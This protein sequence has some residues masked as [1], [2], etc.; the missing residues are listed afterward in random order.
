MRPLLLLAATALALG[1]IRLPFYGAILWAVI[2][3]ALLVP[4]YRRL[5]LHLK[6]RRN[7]IWLPVAAYFFSSGQAGQG[8]ALAA[9]GIFV[10]GLVDKLLRPVLVGKDAGMPDYL[11]MIT[12][13]GGMAVFG[14]NGCTIGPTIAALFMAVWQLSMAA[15]PRAA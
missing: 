5:L 12:T 6:P 14:I 13:L 7:H 10:I 15:P 4:G 1:W 11:V 9:D 3:A 8:L 2:I